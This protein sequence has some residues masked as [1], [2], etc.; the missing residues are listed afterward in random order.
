MTDITRP[1]QR[2]SEAILMALEDLEA[3]EQDPR[4][5]VY[6]DSWHSP[7]PGWNKC[8]VCLAGSVMAK[9]LK[10]SHHHYEV[11]LHFGNPWDKILCALD[12]IRLGDIIGASMV[13]SGGFPTSIAYSRPF[14]V[15]SYHID[16]D[17][18]KAHLR[19]IAEDLQRVGN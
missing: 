5:K 18:F 14:S 4:Y 11:P 9:T 1:P 6:M 8:M 12:Q 17:K 10:A 13:W 7:D 19:E 15:V 16:P 2:M 3:V